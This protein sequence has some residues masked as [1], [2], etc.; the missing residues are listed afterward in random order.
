MLSFTHN[1]KLRGHFDREFEGNLPFAPLVIHHNPKVEKKQSPSR[2]VLMK[3][4]TGK[5]VSAS[6]RKIVKN[7]F[8]SQERTPPKDWVESGKITGLFDTRLRKN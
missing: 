8:P 3:T 2:K 4:V 7:P 6:T 1:D 5:P